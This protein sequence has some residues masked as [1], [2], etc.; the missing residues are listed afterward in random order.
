VTI[1]ADAAMT[2]TERQIRSA[3]IQQTWRFWLEFE[4]IN[5]TDPHH[6]PYRRWFQSVEARDRYAIR[7]FSLSVTYRLI[8]KGEDPC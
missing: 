6:R 8:G 2:D 7:W 3:D 1:P 4:K 5:E